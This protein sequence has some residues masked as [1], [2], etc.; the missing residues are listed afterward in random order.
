MTKY[1]HAM[2]HELSGGTGGGVKYTHIKSQLK[3]V[4][5]EKM[6]E[7]F[8]FCLVF[9]YLCFPFL[10]PRMQKLTDKQIAYSIVKCFWHL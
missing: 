4:R 3:N 6:Y 8:L 10:L 9:W 2:I 7:M 5:E 1:A